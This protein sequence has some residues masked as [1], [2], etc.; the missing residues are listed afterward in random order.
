MKIQIGTNVAVVNS[1]NVPS[2]IFNEVIICRNDI[3]DAFAFTISNMIV[4][5]INY[6]TAT[7]GPLSVKNLLGISTLSTLVGINISIRQLADNTSATEPLQLQYG[8]DN[9]SGIIDFGKASQIQLMGLSDSTIVD[10]SL[11][12]IPV[13]VGKISVLSIIAFIA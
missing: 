5:E 10:I 3:L 2:L 6:S 9:G 11:S 7:A 1:S 4:K 13:A 12:T 8:I